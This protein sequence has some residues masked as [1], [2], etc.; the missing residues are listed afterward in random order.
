MRIK[1]MQRTPAHLSRCARAGVAYELVSVLMIAFTCGFV[2]ALRRI[3]VHRN[4]THVL[5]ICVTT[6]APVSYSLSC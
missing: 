4:S 6:V 3:R 5:T 1:G 2:T